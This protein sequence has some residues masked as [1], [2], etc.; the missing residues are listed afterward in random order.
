MNPH[1]REIMVI[2]TT[3]FVDFFRGEKK[4]EGFLLN[5]NEPLI[6]SR[7]VLMELIRGL[8]SKKDIKILLKQLS[9]LAIELK[10]LDE[11]ISQTAGSLYQTYYH[12]NGLG[13]MDALV[14]ATA[15]VGKNNLITHNLKHFNFIKDLKLIR[16]Y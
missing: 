15:I 2:D 6:I 14:A 10:E 8:K 16:P 9:S 5:T 13:I 3:V 11:A 1:G 12:S 7:A 4:A